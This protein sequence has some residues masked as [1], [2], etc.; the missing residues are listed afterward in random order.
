MILVQTILV[1]VVGV[2]VAYRVGQ[3]TRSESDGCLLM[4]AN[5]V[6]APFGAAIGYFIAPY[7]AYLFTSLLGALMLPTVATAVLARRMS[8]NPD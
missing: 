2:V 4:I 6:L 5:L 7:P 3:L 1:M 8:R